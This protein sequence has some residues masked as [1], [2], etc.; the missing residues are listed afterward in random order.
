M[1]FNVFFWNTANQRSPATCNVDHNKST[2]QGPQGDEDGSERPISLPTPTY[3]NY[4][5]IRDCH[6]PL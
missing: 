2:D 6:R 1:F 5:T 4:H 3:T